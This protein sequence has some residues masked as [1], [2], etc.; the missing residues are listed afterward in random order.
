MLKRMAVWLEIRKFK[1]EGLTQE[2]NYEQTFLY[3]IVLKVKR[4][5]N[6]LFDPH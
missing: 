5:T 6:C 4:M 2:G 1:D 3:S